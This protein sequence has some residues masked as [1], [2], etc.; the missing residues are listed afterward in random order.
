[1]TRGKCVCTNMHGASVNQGQRN[2][3]TRKIAEAVPH[4]VVNIWCMAYKLELAMLDAI[5]VSSMFAD[6]VKECIDYVYM[7]Y[8][9]SS[10]RPRNLKQIGDSIEEDDAYF[11]APQ[12]IRWM[13]SRQ[14]AY[15]ALRQNLTMVCAQVEDAATAKDKKQQSTKGT[16]G[17]RGV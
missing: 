1:M 2:G 5:K 6:L 13:A 9:R 16:S 15:S 8:Y 10:K 14:R 17:S 3:V 11:S 4:N 12:G 7:F